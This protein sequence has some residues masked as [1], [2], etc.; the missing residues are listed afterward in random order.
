MILKQYWRIVWRRLWIPV[1]L[2]AVVGGASYLTY[3]APA[4]SYSTALR[5]AVGVMP[6]EVPD[7]EFS[8]NSYYAWLASEYL[9]D[10]LT[11]IVSS[12][13]FAAD[14]NRHLTAMG[15]SVQIPPS[16]I[17]GVTIAQK[18]HRILQL[19]LTWGNPDELQAIGQAAVIALQEDSPKYL[20]QLLGTPGAS[21]TIIDE[22]GP[23]FAIPPSLTQRLNLPIRFVL[24]LGAGFALIFLLDF[25][26]DRVYTRSELEGLGVAVLAEVPKQ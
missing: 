4:T 16:I 2:L 23:P 9:A 20:T 1:V 17:S 10:D 3:E 5:F 14:V 26:D 7:H 22:P 6:E 25:L 21:I 18:Q 24:A 15:S 11:S 12:G 13:A 8:Y 19:N